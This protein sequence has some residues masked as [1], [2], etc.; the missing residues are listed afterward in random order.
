MHNHIT[1]PL[2]VYAVYGILYAGDSTSVYPSLAADASRK[3]RAAQISPQLLDSA[4]PNVQARKT[5]DKGGRGRA[6]EIQYRWAI[7]V[8]AGGEEE[9]SSQIAKTVR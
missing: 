7:E 9:R 5:L 3:C 8:G 4:T 1:M 2:M 6:A